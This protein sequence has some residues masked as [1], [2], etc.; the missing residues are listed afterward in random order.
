MDYK[1]KCG[2]TTKF[3]TETKGSNIGLYCK[4]C[5]KWIKWLNKN[6]TRAFEQKEKFIEGYKK[7]KEKIN[8][9]RPFDNIVKDYKPQIEELIKNINYEIDVEMDK[10]PISEA[11]AIRKSAYTYGLGKVLYS[12]EDM[13]NDN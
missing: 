6:E 13:L 1:C 7:C 8:Y 3:F 10:T 11:D 4:E 12:L 2:N 9:D 5:G